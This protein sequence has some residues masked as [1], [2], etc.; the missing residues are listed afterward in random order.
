MTELDEPTTPSVDLSLMPNVDGQTRSE[1]QQ[2]PFP[3]KVVHTS[4]CGST[5][6]LEVQLNTNVAGGLSVNGAVVSTRTA[7]SSSTFQ[8]SYTSSL[9][10]ALALT[11]FP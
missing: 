7:P 3:L 6:S 1:I 4:D 10:D 8:S 5:P 2:M 9:G 11:D